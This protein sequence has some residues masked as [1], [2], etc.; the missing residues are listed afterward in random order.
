MKPVR[1]VTEWTPLLLNGRWINLAGRDQFGEPW[2]SSTVAEIDPEAR[3]ARTVS[4]RPYVFVGP[5]CPDE[6]L[7]SALR[8]LTQHGWDISSGTLEAVTLE[9]AAEFI[10]RMETKPSLSP[11]DKVISEKNRAR[12][13]WKDLVWER[14]ESGMSDDDVAAE[15]GLPVAVLQRLH[16]GPHALEGVDLD[17][18][19][20]AVGALRLRTMG[21]RM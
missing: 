10:A 6:G 17:T 16:D 4:G 15:T 21:W 11:E 3:T 1:R 13:V 2:F 18:A 5:H 8:T 7:L 14:A 19:E 20:E 9:Q 12:R